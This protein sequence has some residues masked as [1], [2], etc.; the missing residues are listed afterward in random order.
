[1][2]NILLN[3]TNKFSNHLMLRYICLVF[4]ICFYSDANANGASGAHKINLSTDYFNKDFDVANYLDKI[5]TSSIP[6]S[7]QRYHIDYAYFY[8]NWIIALSAGNESGSV[9]RN[10]QPFKV[11]NK[12]SSQHI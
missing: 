5:K 4:V 2:S 12:F 10:V 11:Q 9:V 3:I 1:M 7:V 8:N 6:E